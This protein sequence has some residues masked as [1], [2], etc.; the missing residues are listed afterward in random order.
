LCKK[1]LAYGVNDQQEAALLGE[2]R[3]KIER[4]TT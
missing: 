1:F 4:S 2:R 3:Q